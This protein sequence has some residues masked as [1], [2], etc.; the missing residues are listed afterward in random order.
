MARMWG[1]SLLLLLPP[2]LLSS[3]LPSEPTV[4]QFHVTSRIQ[5]RYA[6]TEV[7]G[8]RLDKAP[9]QVV[10]EV[11]NPGTEPQEVTFQIR[12]PEK[13]FIHNFSMTVVL[14]GR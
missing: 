11:A 6:S 9:L 4:T 1:H 10:S 13:A 12:L 2:L 7:R 3:P 8:G 5:L 14:A